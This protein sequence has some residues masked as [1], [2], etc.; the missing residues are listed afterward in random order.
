MPTIRQ[1][2]EKVSELKSRTAI[3]QVLLTYIEAHY[4]DDDSGEAEMTFVRSDHAIVP[5][6]HIKDFQAWLVEQADLADSEIDEWENMQLLPPVEETQEDADDSGPIPKVKT[7]KG[8]NAAR[9][10]TKSSG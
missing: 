4:T 6:D 9:D 1:A 3:L 10:R 7:R 2:L 8:R 5:Q